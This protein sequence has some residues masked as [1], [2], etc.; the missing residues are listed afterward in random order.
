MSEFLDQSFDAPPATDP[1]PCACVEI[2]E[3]PVLTQPVDAWTP[4]APPIEVVTPAP[5]PQVFEVEPAW[6]PPLP[7]PVVTTVTPWSP[8][9]DAVTEIPAPSAPVSAT[10]TVA[11][12]GDG[13][14]GFSIPPTQPSDMWGDLRS[15]GFGVRSTG[16][17]ALDGIIANVGV[18]ANRNVLSTPTPSDF[19]SRG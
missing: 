10:P 13:R 2:A 5:A 16:S 12:L 7:E 3:E 17:P 6:T 8:Y 18:Q 11:L 1:I 14:E 19:L 15:W 4:P 9:N